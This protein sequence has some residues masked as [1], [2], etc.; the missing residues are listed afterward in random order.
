M[1]MAYLTNKDPQGYIDFDNLMV[2]YA[3]GD[4]SIHDK[5]KDLAR[6]YPLRPMCNY[7]A[8]C[9][10]G[11]MRVTSNDR[12]F[13]CVK[14]DILICPPNLNYDD[15]NFSDDFECRVFC[16]SDH[17]I[18]GVLRSK[19]DLWHHAVYIS[20]PIVFRITSVSQEEFDYYFSLIRSKLTNHGDTL[21]KEVLLT[22][23]RAFLLELC[24]F[25][26]KTRSMELGQKLS[27]GKVLFN[28]FI[29]LLSSCDVK[30]QPITTYASQL[31]ITPKYLTML[32]LKYSN[33]T[34]SQWVVQYTTE[35][36]RF[37]LKSSNLSIKEIS[38][39]LGF[40]NMSHFGSYVRKH[41][42]MSPS[43]YRHGKSEH[44]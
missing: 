12:K 40:S 3:E 22:L 29:S 34:A 16:L 8:L 11:E 25:L 13:E 42:G 37:Y 1:R 21:P 36:I 9:V 20:Q 15:I 41:L 27:Q 2:D 10:R 24:F 32:C 18:Q 28:K 7:I 26:E 6:L 31:A 44:Q 35:E 43:E 19:A 38:A 39:K 17:L 14:G 23:V 33:K 4:L 30:R 5:V